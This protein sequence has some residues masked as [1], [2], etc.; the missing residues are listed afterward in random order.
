MVGDP[1]GDMIVRLKNAGLAGRPA[2]LVPFSNLKWAIAEL[3]KQEGY[4]KAVG[5]RGKRVHRWI[6]AELSYDPAG[7]PKI[8]EVKRISKPSR[9]VY[10]GAGEIRPVR[11]GY[12][13]AVYST[14]R[15][16]LSDKAAREARV[17]GE[18]LFQIW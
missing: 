15:G 2:A 3:L 18:A 5:K 8:R 16:V 9:R 11:Q 13:L 14:S 6:E 10:R 12:G 1:V 17:G 7:R 4:L